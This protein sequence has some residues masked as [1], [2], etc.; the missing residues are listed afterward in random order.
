MRIFAT[1][2]C[3]LQL[4][5]SLKLKIFMTD[6]DISVEHR[7]GY[8]IRAPEFSDLVNLAESFMPSE[9]ISQAT[10]ER[11]ILFGLT[12]LSDKEQ[13]FL[14]IATSMLS[15]KDIQKGNA[16]CYLGSYSFRRALGG[17]KGPIQSRTLSRIKK[18]LEEKGLIIRH[19][20]HRHS[21]LEKKGIDLRPLLARI[22]EI[23]DR[24][25]EFFQ[26]TRDYF[27]GQQA[28]DRYDY[29]MDKR[30]MEGGHW[31]HPNRLK[32]TNVNNTVQADKELPAPQPI[33]NNLEDQQKADPKLKGNF[34]SSNDSEPSKTSICSPKGASVFWKGYEKSGKQRHLNALSE[35]RA[36]LELSDQL[37]TYIPVSA[38]ED[39]DENAILGGCYRFIEENFAAK[40]NTD[41]T[42]YWAVKKFG[43]KAVLL[44]ICAIEDITIQSREGWLG[45][46]TTKT[47][48]HL[49]LKT[50]FERIR[51]TRDETS[52]EVDKLDPSL[53]EETTELVPEAKSSGKNK[54][55]KDLPLEEDPHYQLWQD[56]KTYVHNEELMSE[57]EVRSWLEPG[58]VEKIY[59]DELMISTK[60]AFQRDYI[61]TNF[62]QALRL[63][64]KYLLGRDLEVSFCVKPERKR[65]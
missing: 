54:G 14:L 55:L 40:R 23:Q 42:F 11:G 35:L 33:N 50:N 44:L 56:V 32:P 63:A 10:I 51:K 27:E 22:D 1:D 24:A 37:K 4:A 3:G 39:A 36:A 2:F 57:A 61:E 19:Y 38:I 45:Y 15:H 49:D 21:P 5:Y 34:L 43:W 26:E 28:L 6:S 62:A 30:V 59:G 13:K 25:E 8:A 17:T 58:K 60:T 20:D 12:D 52:D 64:L 18:S 46:M 41:Q 29:D 47:K 31:S 65:H 7:P 53:D 9:T 16:F 48:R